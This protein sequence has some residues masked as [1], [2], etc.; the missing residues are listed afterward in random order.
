MTYNPLTNQYR[1]ERGLRRELFSLCCAK[2]A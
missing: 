1:L 2:N